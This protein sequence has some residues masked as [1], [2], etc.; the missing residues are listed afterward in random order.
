LV[1][2]E[3]AM[4]ADRFDVWTRRR[5]ELAVGGLLAALVGWRPADGAFAKKRKHKKLVRNAFGCVE[6][7]GKCRGKDAVCCSDICQGKAPKKGNKDQSRCVAHDASTCQTGQRDQNCGG[8]DILCRGSTGKVGVCETTTGSAPY[9]ASGFFC[10]P[11][12][13]D[14]DCRSVC[15]P[16][17]AC[18]SCGY[19]C[20]GPSCA[21]PDACTG[22][23]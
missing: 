4:D 1:T 17:A 11:C 19:Y 21:G 9:C 10:V 5:F 23:T 18:L 13:T 14:E 15:G 8:V 7:G 22:S 2:K 6:V 3:Y 12:A 16:R 20:P